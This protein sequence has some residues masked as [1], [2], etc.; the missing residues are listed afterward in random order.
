V[1]NASNPRSTPLIHPCNEFCGGTSS[2][3]N[4]PPKQTTNYK[5]QQSGCKLNQLG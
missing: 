3:S 1:H 2:D 4:L 5:Q